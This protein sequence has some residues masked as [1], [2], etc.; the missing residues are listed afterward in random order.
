MT[1][2]AN[3][4]NYWRVPFVKRRLSKIKSSL[5]LVEQLRSSWLA[6]LL[7]FAVSAAFISGVLILHI[8]KGI[9]IGELTRD[10]VGFLGG[11]FYTGF[12]SQVGI[13]FWA[14]SAAICLF[15]AHILSRS[16]NVHK[17]KNFLIASGLLTLLLGLDDVLRRVQ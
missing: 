9:S 8:W 11:S 16:S 15:S 12:L 5:S 6:I 10:P 4:D 14:S 1:A 13:F 2:N 3:I 17:L 7:V